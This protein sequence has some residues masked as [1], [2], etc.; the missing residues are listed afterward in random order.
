MDTAIPEEKLTAISN[1]L[2]AARKIEAIKIY[3]QC[4]GVGLYEAKQAV[5]AIEADLRSAS[6][7][8]FS[9]APG[10]G[11]LGVTVSMVAFGCAL[12]WWLASGHA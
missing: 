12:L 5:E 10:K 8:K 2:F 11:C 3:R 7:E 6:P 9:R 4:T 1:A